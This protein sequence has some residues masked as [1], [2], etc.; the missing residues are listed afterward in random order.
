MA[1]ASLY[2]VSDSV[3]ARVE[4]TAASTE[5]ASTEAARV[6]P[7]VRDC[8]SPAQCGEELKDYTLNPNPGSEWGELAVTMVG[9]KRVGIYKVGSHNVDTCKVDIQAPMFTVLQKDVI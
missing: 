2:P 9:E 3:H 6:R 7:H 1:L 5:A 4:D 8:K